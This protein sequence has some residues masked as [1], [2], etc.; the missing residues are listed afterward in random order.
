MENKAPSLASF[1]NLATAMS[2]IILPSGTPLDYIK[3]V[4]WG[5]AF[6][7]DR[8]FGRAD[9]ALIDQV[10]I[11]T[12]SVSS[13]PRST[14]GSSTPLRTA[15][16]NPAAH[17]HRYLWPPE[18]CRGTAQRGNRGAHILRSAARTD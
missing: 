2:A 16:G 5:D 11:A 17:R 3:Q 12:G 6:A 4:I 7:Q 1:L 15:V 9:P 13:R 10:K 8:F 18:L 14:P